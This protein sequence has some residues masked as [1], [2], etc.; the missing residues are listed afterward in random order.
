MDIPNVF[1]GLFS[2]IFIGLIVENLI[3]RTIE[4]RTL[5]K[6]GMLN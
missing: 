2:V 4:T 3:F 1:A 6:W 5:R